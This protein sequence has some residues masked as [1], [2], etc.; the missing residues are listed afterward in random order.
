MIFCLGV[1]F[2]VISI[3][4]N[5]VISVKKR[6]WVDFF[7]RLLIAIISFIQGFFLTSLIVIASNYLYIILGRQSFIIDF[8]F[9]TGVFGALYYFA[10][11]DKYDGVKA[12]LK[13]Y[14]K[15]PKENEIIC[16]EIIQFIN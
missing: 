14:G 15:E 7:K 1:I 4:I 3:F 2:F 9:L 6:L 5:E 13:N 12:L 10:F 8:T 16:D 11:I